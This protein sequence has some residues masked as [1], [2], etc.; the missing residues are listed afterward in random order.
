MDEMKNFSVQ[1]S[2]KLNLPR[3]L[4]IPSSNIKLLETVGQGIINVMYVVHYKKITLLL[5]LS[6]EFGIVYKGHIIK[7]LG[8]IV[9]DIVAVKTLKGTYYRLSYKNSTFAM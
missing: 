8:Q 5:Y 6:G 3:Y 9:T 2:Y 4:I 7:I 1:S